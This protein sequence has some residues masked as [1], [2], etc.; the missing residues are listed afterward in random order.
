MKNVQQTVDI[1]KQKGNLF[2]QLWE[3]AEQA[4]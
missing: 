3:Q 1:E 2:R 4:L